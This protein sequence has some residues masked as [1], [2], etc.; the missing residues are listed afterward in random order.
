MKREL[1]IE[2]SWTNSSGNTIIVIN[3]PHDIENVKVI[4]TEEVEEYYELL[5]DGSYIICNAGDILKL[6][7]F[8]E[9]DISCPYL[10]ELECGEKLWFREDDVKPSTKEAYENQFKNK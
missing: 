9:E 4:L 8:D 10:L 2:R 1:K 6:V 5:T 7:E 3:G